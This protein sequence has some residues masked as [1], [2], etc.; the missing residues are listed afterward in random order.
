MACGHW[1]AIKRQFPK[2]RIVYLL[3]DPIE[4]FHSQLRMAVRKGHIESASE[5]FLEKLA[6]PH[7]T[8]RSFYNETIERLDEVFASGEVHVAFFET[9]FNDDAVGAL[10]DFLGCPFIPGEYGKRVNPGGEPEQ[11]GLNRTAIEA[12]LEKF[13][14][15]YAFC[16]ER[17]GDRV[18]DRW[19][20]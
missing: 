8:E 19:L 3:R 15:V 20:G 9:F 2:V 5:V 1:L 14:D 10:C 17:F 13:A 4:R 11:D 12:G 7:L 18:P 16:R 6:S